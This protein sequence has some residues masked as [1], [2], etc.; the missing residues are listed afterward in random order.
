MPLALS[1][2]VWSWSEK[3]NSWWNHKYEKIVKD[4]AFT[5][6]LNDVERLT[7]NW[8]IHDSCL[9]VHHQ[10]SKII[11][12][13]QPDSTIIYCSISSAQH[14]SGNILPIIRSV[15][16]RYLQHMIS[17]CCGGQVDGER[18]VRFQ[19]FTTPDLGFNFLLNVID[20]MMS[21]WSWNMLRVLPYIVNWVWIRGKREIFVMYN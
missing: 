16:L 7:W 15:R 10:L 5:S 19:S 13:N 17:C 2:F 6:T 11:Q 1:G 3:R 21:H 18:Q 20:F 12:M 14:V 4:V 9:T 8:F